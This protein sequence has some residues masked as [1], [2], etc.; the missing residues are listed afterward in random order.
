MNTYH[1]DGNIICVDDT[2]ATDYE[3]MSETTTD[4]QKDGTSD[5][6]ITIRGY[7]HTIEESTNNLQNAISQFKKTIGFLEHKIVVLLGG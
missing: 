7:G 5:I 2:I 1:G 3:Y 6:F 4:I